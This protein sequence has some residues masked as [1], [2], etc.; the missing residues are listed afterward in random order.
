LPGPLSNITGRSLT[1]PWY[2]MGRSFTIPQ[3]RT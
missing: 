2:I 1:I 3:Y